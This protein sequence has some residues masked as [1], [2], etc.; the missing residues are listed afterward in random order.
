M[1]TAFTLLILFAIVSLNTIAQDSAQWGVTAGAKA[2]LDVGMVDDLEFSPVGTILAVASD[3]GVRLYDSATDDILTLKWKNNLSS[4]S[5]AFSPDGRTLATADSDVAVRLW[6]VATGGQKDRLHKDGVPAKLVAFSPDGRTVVS[7]GLS[8]GYIWDALTGTRKHTWDIYGILSEFGHYDNLAFSPDGKT[9]ASGSRSGKV[10]DSVGAGS[11]ISLRSA[12]TGALIDILHFSGVPTDVA[13]S[14]DGRTLACSSWGGYVVMR[15]GV[16]LWD[17][18]TWTKKPGLGP[19]QFDNKTDIIHSIAYSPDNRTVAGGGDKDIYIWDALTRTPEHILEGHTDVV[20][21]IVFSPEGRTLAS[22]SHDGTVLLWEIAPSAE[23][24][25]VVKPQVVEPLQ[26]APDVNSDGGVDIRDVLLVAGRLGQSAQT[27]A[28]VNG[29]KTVNVLDVVLVAGMVDNLSGVLPIYPY[30]AVMPRTT[31]VKLWLEAAWES[32]LPEPILLRG[33]RFLQN[34]LTA[35]TPNETVLL[36]N[37]P[38]PFNPETWIP[39]QLA[40]DVGVQISIYSAKGVLVRHLHLGRQPAGFYTDKHHAA[41][42]DGR[43]ESGELV[44]NGLYVYEFRAG[45]YRASRRMAIV[46]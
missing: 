45:S 6:D 28:D 36:P 37:Y 5:V 13:F 14:P 31:E 25:Q 12:V 19:G 46:K 23:V 20:N 26:V 1:K 27:P 29:D 40:R 43:N 34:L 39:Y 32:G 15:G 4:Y 22:G 18:A 30:G 42:W 33:I 35:L 24:L 44:T 9:R 38:N 11:T 7:T 21:S 16:S 3:S 2:R 10:M 17:V 41:Y 8:G